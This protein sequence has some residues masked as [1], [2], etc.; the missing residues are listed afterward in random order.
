[1]YRVY[2]DGLAPDSWGQVMIAMGLGQ[3]S[4]ATL[5]RCCKLGFTMLETQSDN[6]RRQGRPRPSHA[7]GQTS[8][9]LED[10]VNPHI[11]LVEQHKRR[12]KIGRYLGGSGSGGRDC[13][14]W[15]SLRWQER[16]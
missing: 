9:V 16:G 7:G 4:V 14:R 15:R 11:G 8:G 5:N 13:E 2:S 10:P 12:M 6:Q 3:E 1:M